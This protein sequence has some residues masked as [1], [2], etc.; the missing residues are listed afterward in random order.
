MSKPTV[1]SR[2]TLTNVEIALKTFFWNQ[3]RCSFHGSGSELSGPLNKNVFLWKFA[4][5]QIPNKHKGKK[6]RKTTYSKWI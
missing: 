1:A 6:D 2:K 5:K 3:D 4:T